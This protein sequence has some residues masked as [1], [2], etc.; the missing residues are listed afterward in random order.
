[1]TGVNKPREGKGAEG[2]R[3]V[4]RNRRKRKGGRG[5]EGFGRG[6]GGTEGKERKKGIHVDQKGREEK[7]RERNK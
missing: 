5:G 4:E 1:M 7:R 6:K 2:K 3:L